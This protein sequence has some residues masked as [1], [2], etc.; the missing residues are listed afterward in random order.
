MPHTAWLLVFPQLSQE[1]LAQLAPQLTQMDP[2]MGQLLLKT[3]RMLPDSAVDLMV[4]MASM[5]PSVT[6][7][8]K[9][10]VY[11]SWLNPDA[12][13]KSR[14]TGA[15]EEGLP[16]TKAMSAKFYRDA[17]AKAAKAKNCSEDAAAEAVSGGV[18]GSVSGCV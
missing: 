12:E 13:D 17:A 2:T 15:K 6:L 9:T 18:V 14:S 8:S 10:K 3:L 1:Q 4:R 11:I 7:P 16:D 5:M